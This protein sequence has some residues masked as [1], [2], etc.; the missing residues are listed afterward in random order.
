V[1]VQNGS[2]SHHYQSNPLLFL[3]EG[4]RLQLPETRP[5]VDLIIYVDADADERA[6]RV[7]SRLRARPG[8]LSLDKH[9]FDATE[10]Y[11]IETLGVNKDD[12]DIVI[13]NNDFTA[14]K[15]LKS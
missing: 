10:R 13:D 14:P 15:I 7:D 5:L 8:N 3:T 11:V 12:A 2:S 6:H 9:F 1:N 4:T